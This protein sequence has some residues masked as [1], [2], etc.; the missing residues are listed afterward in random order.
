MTPNKNNRMEPVTDREVL[1]QM[2][3]KIDNFAET[4]ERIAKSLNNLE[5]VKFEAHENRIAKLEKF[6]NQWGGALIA[7]NIL[8]VIV[9]LI[10]NFYKAWKP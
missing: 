2:S 7:F 3:G 8:V 6:I 1:I 9:G 10:I 4:M 5:T